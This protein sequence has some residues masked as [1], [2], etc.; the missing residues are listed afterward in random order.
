MEEG[1][2]PAVAARHCAS[3]PKA[4]CSDQ[5]NPSSLGNED[6]ISDIGNETVSLPRG[7]HT[8]LMRALGSQTTERDTQIARCPIGPH[9]DTPSY[10]L[11]HRMVVKDTVGWKTQGE[12]FDDLTPSGESVLTYQVQ[13]REK[14]GG[15]GA[16]HPA[17]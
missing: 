6:Q 4:G 13:R 11:S 9:L 16:R 17:V 12:H 1:R 7:F 8:G 15:T 10:K 2:R 3:W 14:S 5:R